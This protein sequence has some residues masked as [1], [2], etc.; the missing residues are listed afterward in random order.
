MLSLL[1][2]FFCKVLKLK[3]KQHSSKKLH[4]LSLKTIVQFK[5]VKSIT[6]ICI[7]NKH[8]DTFFL[9]LECIVKQSDSIQYL[10]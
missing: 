10:K 5:Q 9:H 1:H 2:L 8:Y 7:F 3:R 6:A 4:K